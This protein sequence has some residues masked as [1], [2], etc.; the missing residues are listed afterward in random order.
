MCRHVPKVP[1]GSYAPDYQ[2]TGPVYALITIFTWIVTRPCDQTNKQ[3]NQ[4]HKPMILY[5][6]DASVNFVYDNLQIYRVS[7][8]ILCI[9]GPGGPMS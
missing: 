4:M 9:K 3:T 5:V 7:F 6:C 8:D 2:T 1:D